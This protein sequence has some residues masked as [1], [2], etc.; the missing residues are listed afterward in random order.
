MSLLRIQGACIA[1][2]AQLLENLSLHMQIQPLPRMAT[3]FSGYFIRP[4][5]VWTLESSADRAYSMCLPREY[6]IIYR[7]PGFLAA[8]WFCS[9]PPPPP[10]L[11]SVCPAPQTRRLRKRDNL[12]TG[13]G[14]D[15]GLG[16]KSYDGEKAWTSLIIQ[17]SLCLPFAVWWSC[18]EKFHVCKYSMF[19]SIANICTL[20]QVEV[21]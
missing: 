17:Y 11:P 13:E 9:F 3:H 8:V 18:A 19:I 20:N 1:K 6:G 5:Q 14:G 21:F 2:T 4:V 15:G 10:L 12:L 16:A 7:G